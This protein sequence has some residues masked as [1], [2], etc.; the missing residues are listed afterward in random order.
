MY[1]NDA[2]IYTIVKLFII[3]LQKM[4]IELVKFT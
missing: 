4:I 1:I 2:L 3:K